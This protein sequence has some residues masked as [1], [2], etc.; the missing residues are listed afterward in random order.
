MVRRKKA[1]AMKFADQW[2]DLGNDVHAKRGW[3]IIKTKPDAQWQL[4][5]M[6]SYGGLP[7]VGVPAGKF[8]ILDAA[9]YFADSEGRS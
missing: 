9:R 7:A 4:Y 8:P 5:R 1:T 3:S 6:T 2:E